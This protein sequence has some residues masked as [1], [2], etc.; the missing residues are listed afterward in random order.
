MTH[1]DV[2]FEELGGAMTHNSISGVAHMATESEADCFALIREMLTYLPQN[3][4][5]DPPFEA[6][7]DDPLR[8]D[9]R[10]D[11]IIPDNANKPYDIKEVI[12]LIVDEGHFYENS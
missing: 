10:L 6:A 4:L 3:N 8:M 11:S 12:R 7:T 1:E 5:E 9:M 2:T